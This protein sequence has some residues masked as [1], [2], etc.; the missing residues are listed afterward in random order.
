MRTESTAGWI[1]LAWWLLGAAG[2]V[3]TGIFSGWTAAVIFAVA[4]LAV[5]VPG[6]LLVRRRKR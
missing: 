2:V 1:T 6:R 4:Y 5:F 3:A